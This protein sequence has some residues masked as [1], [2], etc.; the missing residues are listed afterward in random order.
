ME[1]PYWGIAVDLSL[2]FR[3]KCDRGAEQTAAGTLTGKWADNTM[4]SV[5]SV[6]RDKRC[7]PRGKESKGVDFQTINRKPA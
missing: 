2:V 5:R 3:E 7:D 6:W 4:E 1:N